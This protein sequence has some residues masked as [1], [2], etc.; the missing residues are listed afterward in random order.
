MSGYLAMK[1]RSRMSA[2][3][4]KALIGI[5]PG[6]KGPLPAVNKGN[7]Y[8]TLSSLQLYQH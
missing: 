2:P 8:A 6:N 7:R 4:A 5:N 1:N 3:S